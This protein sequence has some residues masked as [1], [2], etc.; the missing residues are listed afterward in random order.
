MDAAVRLV[1]GGGI[2]LHTFRNGQVNGAIEG[3][4]A[5]VADGDRQSGY[6]LC[7]P[8]VAFIVVVALAA[9]DGAVT[10]P[11]IAIAAVSLDGVLALVVAVGGDSSL[12]A[13][14]DGSQS[15]CVAVEVLT[16]GVG[17]EPVRA[18]VPEGGGIVCLCHLDC[19]VNN[20]QTG[21]GLRTLET[22]EMAWSGRLHALGLCLGLVGKILPKGNILNIVAFIDDAVTCWAYGLV[23]GTVFVEDV[24]IAITQVKER[25]VGTPV[26]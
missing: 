24:E 20:S 3:S 12:V 19:T 26:V 15:L 25:R 7:N 16:C 5:K 11:V 21:I 4:Q 1:L 8:C 22:I 14:A 2:D 9:V 13:G 6:V 10:V 18:V 17:Y 23:L